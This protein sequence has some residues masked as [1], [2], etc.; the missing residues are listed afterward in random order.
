MNQVQMRAVLIATDAATAAVTWLL[1]YIYRIVYIENAA[2]TFKGNVYLGL[3]LFPLFSVVLYT[4]QGT[5]RDVFRNY[6]IKTLKNTLF[7]TLIGGLFIFLTVVINDDV[8]DY[9]QFYT[10]LFGFSGLHFFV[11]LVPRMVH[12]TL[13][14]RK[15]H[16]GEFGFKT[17][18][19]GGGERAVQLLEEMRQLKY[20]PGY[21]FVGF[22]AVNGSDRQLQDHLPY[23]GSV[24][25]MHSLLQ[26]HAVEE[27]ILALE[28]S[29]HKRLKDII[30]RLSNS[31]MRIRIIPDAYDILS[32]QV[33]MD[34]VFG[35]L[36]LS[37]NC[38]PMPDWQFSTKRMM[39][40]VIAGT[41]LIAL[42]P[43]Y[44]LLALLIGLDSK[45]P[46]LFKQ[47]RIGRHGRPFQII[48]FRTM[49]LNAE[50]NGPQL[51]STHDNRITRIGKLLR[52]VRL[53]ELPQF[54]N[55]LIGE[56]SLV[57]PRPER[58]FY[59]DQIAKCDAQYRYLHKVRPGITSWGQVKFGY[60][61]S[62]SQ[63]IQRMKYDLLY[64]RNMSLALDIKIMFYT[65]G[66]IFRGEGK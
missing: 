54:W 46:I 17:V 34:S 33:K 28:S 20:H 58:R 22:I 51:S 44:L 41:A 13:L 7:G 3:V 31:D 8:S 5:Y 37:V 55:V 60:A 30:G 19:I 21:D 63:M 1:L 11:T 61:E 29:D 39:D 45:G 10:L 64:I 16:R 24:D 40:I 2:I 62:V 32:G 53:D 48:K 38:C 23:L 47:E 12:T 52:K 65:I 26:T 56:M 50:R 6:R 66:I 42:L 43:L 4:I 59:I 36:L 49:Q 25:E 14:V 27:V 35:A 9:T 18:V 15:I 57:G